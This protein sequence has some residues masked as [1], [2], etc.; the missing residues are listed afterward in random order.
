MN[1]K[2]TISYYEL[3][4]LVP[5]KMAALRLLER[6]RWGTSGRICPFCGH[7]H[8]CARGGTRAGYYRCCRCH[9][10]FTV[11]TASIFERSHIP[12]DKWILA[13]YMMV[14]ARKGVS[15][16]QLSKELS[17]RQNSAW[18]M[19]HRIRSSMGER[20]NA[21]LKGIVEIDESCIGREES[22]KY[23]SKKLKAGWGSIGKSAAVGIR[24]C[25]GRILAKVVPN[26]KRQT[27]RPVMHKTVLL[28]PVVSTD[29]FSRYDGLSEQYPHK[30]VNHSAKPFVDAMACTNGIESVW[31]VL[32]RGCYGIFHQFSVKHLQRYVD[33]FAFR[34][35][36]GNCKVP[37]LERMNALFNGVWNRRLNYSSLVGGELNE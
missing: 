12:L 8:S 9:K 25:K 18:F 24:R 6:K 15:S 29:D 33:E 30:V 13:I 28:G 21:F 5:D 35:N 22:N 26:T 14:T 10:E 3:T 2:T 4:K 17:I 34:L 19:M 11:R 36:E 7:R 32:K 37:T 31:A 27:F 23:E 1:D 16:L 20:G